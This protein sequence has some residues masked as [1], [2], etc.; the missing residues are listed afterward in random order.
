MNIKIKEFGFFN[1]EYKIKEFGF[2]ND[3][4]KNKGVW[5]L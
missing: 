3:E 2:F 1:D 4:Y 5:L